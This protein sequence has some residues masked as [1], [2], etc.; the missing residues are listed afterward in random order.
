MKPTKEMT[1]H[2]DVVLKALDILDCFQSQP[3]LTLKEIADITHLTR[4]RAM[5]LAGTLASRGYLIYDGEQRHFHLGP[6]LFTLGKIFETHHTLISLA[7]PILRDLVRQ[8]GELASLYVI[9]GTERVAL[10]REKGTHEISYTVSEGQRME[11]YAGA[12]GK[13]LLAHAPREVSEKV[14][15]AKSLKKLTPN[16]ISS[17]TQLSRQLE[18][19]RSKGYS[20]SEGER[21]LDVWSVAAPVFDHRRMICCAIGITGPIYRI[22]KAAQSDFINTVIHKARE[23]TRHLGGRESHHEKE[24]ES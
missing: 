16:T 11:L 18:I 22:P 3:V 10:A 1:R 15:S 5:R 24:G 6:R 7:R 21:A 19:I 23:L 13:V 8:T 4:S 2:V 9:D 20:V 17:T 14:I 12:A